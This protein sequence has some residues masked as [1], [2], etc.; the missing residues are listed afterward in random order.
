MTLTNG[1]APAELRLPV[2]NSTKS[3][4][5]EELHELADH[6]STSTLPQECDVL[7]VGSGYAGVSTAYSLVK[8]PGSENIDSVVILEAR[9]ACSGATGRNGGHLRPDL[10]GHI[11]VYIERHGIEAGA[12]YA[13]FEVS[14][15]QA[16]KNLIAKEG[17]ECDFT[18]TRS[19]DTWVDE[20]GE[21]HLTFRAQF[22]NIS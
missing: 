9:E 7:I 14:H 15:V 19:T 10:Y 6:Q 12:E 3:F 21:I 8:G 20:E 5:H 18:L 4:W 1:A 13:E 22:A 17:I 11:P 2:P 16:I